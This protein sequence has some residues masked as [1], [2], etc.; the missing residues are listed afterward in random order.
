MLGLFFITVGAAID[1]DVLFSNTLLVVALTLGIM[2]VKGGILAVLAWVFRIRDA[3]LFAL[4]LAQ[5]G[6]F[7]FVLLSFA[8]TPSCLAIS[9]RSCR[10]WWPF[11]CFSPVLFIAYE[12][13]VQPRFEAEPSGRRTR[14]TRA[15]PC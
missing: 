12:Q 8:T 4:S 5:A 7:G 11:R 10:W 15:A 6:E 3:W 1:T 9:A 14:S 2:A 13:L